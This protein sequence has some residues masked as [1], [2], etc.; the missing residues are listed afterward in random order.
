MHPKREYI[1]RLQASI[2]VKGFVTTALTV[3][4][5]SVP[6]MAAHAASPSGEERTAALWYV[7]ALGIPAAKAE[8]LT[9]KGMRIAV[10]DDGINLQ[11]SELQGANINVH[12]NYCLNQ[13]TGKPIPAD[14]PDGAISQHGTSVVAMLVGNGR[15]SDGGLG[16]VGIVPD[17]QI[18]FYA[19]GPLVTEEQE[20]AGWDKICPS[21]QGSDGA[22]SGDAW[23]NAM[24]DA[25]SSGASFVSVSLAGSVTTFKQGLVDAG[26]LGVTVVASALNPGNDSLGVG[27]FPA[28]GNGTVAV[29]AV[30]RDNKVIG[31]SDGFGGGLQVGNGNMTV[32]APGV[33]ILSMNAQWQPTI[34]HGTSYA[35]PLLTG[36]LVL[37]SQKYPKATHNQLLQSLI[38]TTD[39][40]LRD[41]ALSWENDLGYGIASL[42]EMLSRDP[43]GFPDV[44]P[45]FVD[46]PS[47]P[48]CKGPRS[49]AQPTTMEKCRWA[50]YPTAQEI[51]DAKSSSNPIAKPE[52]NTKK[53]QSSG[54]LTLISAIGAGI[55]VLVAAGVSIP[56]LVRRRR[57][58][59]ATF[60]QV[61]GA[62]L[63]QTGPNYPVTGPGAGDPKNAGVQKAPI[64]P[65]SAPIRPAHGQGTNTLS[66]APDSTRKTERNEE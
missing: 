60:V 18:D 66:D 45:I 20:A 1:K 30:G 24:N 10:V 47:D 6:P 64:H 59:S 9:G 48:R 62:G 50:Q 25:V 19:A 2:Q 46:D 14:S 29:N 38:N 49:S 39:K 16:T 55:V 41:G 44:N 23:R 27:A 57:R 3:A 31:R 58:R 37:T 35:A 53:S 12:G 21:S 5:L 61:E 22:F 4:L 15:A 56:M 13:D 36:A 7:D 33:R 40:S 43:S 17:A 54:F 63:Q 34:E 51:K 32:G 28:A 42:P 26:R 65:G 8:G 11:A 52:D